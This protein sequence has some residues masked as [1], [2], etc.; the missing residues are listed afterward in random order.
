MHSFVCMR[1]S[2][3]E[4][5]YTT[6]ALGGSASADGACRCCRGRSREGE[7]EEEE[8]AGEREKSKS[9]WAADIRTN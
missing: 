8:G 3:Y 4:H 9:K 1:L 2:V 5:N 6:E 7:E